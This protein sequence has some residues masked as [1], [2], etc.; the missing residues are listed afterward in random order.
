[1]RLPFFS[2]LF[3]LAVAVA[4]SGTASAAAFSRDLGRGLVYYRI[5]TLPTDLPSS[6]ATRKQPCVL[7]LRYAHG[8]SAAAAGMQAWLKFYASPRTPVFIL[9]NSQTDRALL[10]AFGARGSLGSVLVLGP[11]S[12][13]FT[14]DISIRTSPEAERRAYDALAAVADPLAL[15]AENADKARNDEASLSRDR[16]TEAAAD[17]AASTSSGAP[18]GNGSA[19]NHSS[20]PPFD[21]TLQRAVQLHRTLIALRKV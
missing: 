20:P 19:K 6:A 14:P 13:E 2:T 18:A 11:S 21:A 7:D 5:E 1:M 16:S 15:L 10:Q 9:V 8:D 12:P 17:A 4:S 3:A